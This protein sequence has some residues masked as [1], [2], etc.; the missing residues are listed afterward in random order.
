MIKGINTLWLMICHIMKE[1]LCIRYIHCLAGGCQFISKTCQK[2]FCDKI[3]YW[4]I[5][6]LCPC[7]HCHSYNIILRSCKRKTKRFFFF[8][9][10]NHLKTF[11]HILYALKL[12]RFKYRWL[13]FFI[14]I[15]AYTMKF[16]TVKLLLG[17]CLVNISTKMLK[18]LCNRN[19]CLDCRK[20]LT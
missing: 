16:K 18:R 15:N 12:K 7:C 19:I 4:K 3:D 14:K 13:L 17:S 11:I 5:I 20:L 2:I 9:R 8:E 1:L 6:S 10:T